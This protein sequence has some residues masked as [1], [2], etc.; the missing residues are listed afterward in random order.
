MLDDHWN[1]ILSWRLHPD[2]MSPGST[3]H[4][5]R[6]ESCVYLHKCREVRHDGASGKN[7]RLAD[8]CAAQALACSVA[9]CLA[10]IHEA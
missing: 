8:S 1:S 2:R 5:R 4:P 7:G 3:T 6:A 10:T 9:C